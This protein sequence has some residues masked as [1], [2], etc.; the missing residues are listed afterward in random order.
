M[1]VYTALYNTLDHSDM[2]GTTTANTTNNHNQGCMV[3]DRRACVAT[4]P[5]S[6]RAQEQRCDANARHRMAAILRS[7][8]QT[9]TNG[10]L[11]SGLVGTCYQHLRGDV[12]TYTHNK[13]AFSSPLPSS[14]ISSSTSFCCNLLRMWRLRRAS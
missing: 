4:I 7:G 14:H 8:G 3:L 6:N 13:N 10:G 1:Y 5:H 9:Q 2:L 12:F 11:T